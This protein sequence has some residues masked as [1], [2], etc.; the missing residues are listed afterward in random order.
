M[1]SQSQSVIDALQEIICRPEHDEQKIAQYFAA[2]Y[3]QIV[4]GKSLSYDDFINHMR[5]LKVQT[6]K[7]HLIVKAA[8]GEGDTVFTQHYV[9]VEKSETEWSE[10]EVFARFTLLAG[11]IHRCE[12]VTRMIHGVSEDSDFGSRR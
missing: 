6:Q 7:M 11:K 1:K 4:D 8:V 5:A 2:D 10:F 3:R 12:E 9:K